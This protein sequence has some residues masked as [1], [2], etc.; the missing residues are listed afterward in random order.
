MEAWRSIGTDSRSSTG[1]IASGCSTAGASGR[2]AVTSGAL[3][4]VIPVASSW[5][6]R[7]SVHFG[8]R[9]STLAV[10]RLAVVCAGRTLP[11][12]SGGDRPRSEPR[13]PQ[14]SGRR[15]PRSSLRGRS[16]KGSTAGKS[17]HTHPEGRRPGRPPRVTRRHGGVDACVTGPK[18]LVWTGR[19]ASLRDLRPS[20]ATEPAAHAGLV[21]E[22]AQHVVV[23]GRER[24][25]PRCGSRSLR[26]AQTA[27]RTNLLCMGCHRCWFVEQGYLVEVNRYA[28]SGCGDR[29]R[30]RPL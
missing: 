15:G 17:V 23:T 27:S 8:M 6:A 2:I 21:H 7:R 19:M 26:Q 22:D 9:L 14:G 12:R 25:C 30:C 16:P 11:D 10:A 5:T 20:P 13:E 28:C 3:P 1:R 4:V 29:T 18:G 24:R